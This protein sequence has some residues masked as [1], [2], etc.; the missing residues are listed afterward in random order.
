MQS[1]QKILEAN[2]EK[3][4]SGAKRSQRSPSSHQTSS[5]SNVKDEKRACIDMLFSKFAAFYGHVWRSQFKSED[6]MKFAKKEWSLGL[7]NFDDATIKNAI[8]NC[9]DFYEMP[10]TLPQVIRVCRDIKKRQEFSTAKKEVEPINRTLA[11]TQ[12]KN[13]KSILNNNRR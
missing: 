8:T 9:R 13:C 10:P 11:A 1:V 3:I 12:L 6:F 5:N 7:K 2:Q 4:C